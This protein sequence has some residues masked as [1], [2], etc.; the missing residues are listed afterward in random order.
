MFVIP[1]D[2]SDF[3]DKVFQACLKNRFQLRLNA[4]VVAGPGKVR[5]FWRA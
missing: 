5:K 2:K 3:R 4:M 1:T